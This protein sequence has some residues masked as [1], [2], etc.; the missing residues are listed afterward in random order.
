M[1]TKHRRPCATELSLHL[2]LLGVKI[3][4]EHPTLLRYPPIV[5]VPFHIHIRV[6]VI[7]IVIVIIIIIYDDDDDDDD[8]D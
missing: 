3:Q 7:V 6:I 4:K 5:S 1:K 8:D 2:L